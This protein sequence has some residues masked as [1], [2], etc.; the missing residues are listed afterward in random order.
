[1]IMPD[2][3]SCDSCPAYI[4]FLRPLH[5]PENGGFEELERAE[6]N[7]EIYKN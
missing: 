2:F 4:L 3:N 6:A 1:M 5:E 7:P